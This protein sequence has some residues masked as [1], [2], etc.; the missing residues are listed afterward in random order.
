MRSQAFTRI[1]VAVDDSR[2]ALAAV[3]AA[4]ALAP[5]TGGRLR[6][7]HVMGDGD[8]IR[9]LARMGRDGKLPAERT[10]AADSLL[11]HVSAEAQRAGVEAE[12]ASETG[13]PA[14]RLLAAAREWEADLVV[15][16]R[17]DVRGAGRAYVGA[18]TRAVLEFSEIPVLVVPRPD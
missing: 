3:H 16:G 12:T 17:S 18:V 1:L 9:A 10:R 8:L 15:M 5:L 11:R 4:V 13:E 7:V 6:F 2:T 14:A